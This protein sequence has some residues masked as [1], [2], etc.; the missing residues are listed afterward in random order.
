[1]YLSLKIQKIYT[2]YGIWYTISLKCSIQYS[3]I[4]V[5]NQEGVIKMF[6]YLFYSEKVAQKAEK[7]LSVL[8][9]ILKF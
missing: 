9:K 2:N 1:M 6:N 5:T 8:R 4:K 7:K 3:K